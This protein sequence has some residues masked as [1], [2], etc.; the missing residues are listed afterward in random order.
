MSAPSHYSVIFLSS[1]DKYL[2]V[3]P[4]YY[5][6]QYGSLVKLFLVVQLEVRFRDTKLPLL[7]YLHGGGFL[8]KSAFSLTYHAHFNVVVA[9]A[10]IWHYVHPKSTGVDDPLLNSRMESNL[11]RLGFVVAKKVG[12]F[13]QQEC[14]VDAFLS[15]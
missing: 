10:G 6:F 12:Y 11:L 13:H 2:F 8:I 7:V 3:L 5:G 15:G 1:S 4:L 14:C 9:E